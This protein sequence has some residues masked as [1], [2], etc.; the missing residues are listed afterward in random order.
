MSSLTVNLACPADDAALRRILRETWMPGAIAVTFEREPGYFCAAAIEGPV[1]QT[2]VVREAGSGEVVGMGSRSVRP[3][4]LNGQVQPVGYI[5]QLRSSPRYGW[6]LSLA[7]TLAKGFAFH[8]VLHADGQARFYLCSIVADN[9]PARRLLASG[10]PGL[11][12]FREYTRL[13]TYAVPLGR[14]RAPAR[15]PRPL[16]LERGTWALAGPILDCLQRNG[17]RR[18]FAPHWTG[19][20]LF[21]P[22]SAPGLAPGDFVLVMDGQRVA[23]CLAVWDQSP[24]KQMV[25]RGYSGTLARWRRLINAAAR[26]GAWPELPPPNARFN[27]CYASHLAVDDDDPQIFAALL[28]AGY[29]QARERGFNYFA[30][31]LSDAHPLRKVVTRTYRPVTYTSQLYLVAWDDGLEAVAQ[32]DGRVPG[33]EIAI[34]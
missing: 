27:Y 22:E 5:S 2:L 15:L 14:R 18:Q 20:T 25:V 31:G 24:F 7:R 9:W 12:V 8:R 26:L 28:R 13:H 10:L 30:L 4:F 16:R 3:M 32:V 17:P 33:P 19:D 6:G 1:H 29:S 23:G 21:S 11:P 34:L